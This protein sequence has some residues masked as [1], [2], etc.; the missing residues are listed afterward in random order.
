MKRKAV[1]GDGAANAAIRRVGPTKPRQ[2]RAP[3]R[4]I[5]SVA[6]LSL[7]ATGGLFGSTQPASAAN[8]PSYADVQAARVSEAAKQAEITVLNQILTTLQAQVQKTQ[9]VADKA[10]RDAQTAQT[11]FDDASHTA[12]RYAVVADAARQQST[13]SRNQAGEI[14]AQLAQSG[15][16]DLSA[17]I[18]FSGHEAD[19]LLSKLGLARMLKDQAAGVYQTATKEARSVTALTQQASVAKDALK[20]LADAARAA[21]QLAASEAQAAAAALADQQSHQIELNA[22]LAALTAATS[23]TEADYSAGVEAARVAAAAAAAAANQGVASVPTGE[24]TASGWT[25]PSAGHISSPYGYRIDPYNGVYALHEG[26]DLA[27]GC[28]SPIYAA[29]S[30]TVVLAG[31]YGGYGNYIRIQNSGDSSF[32]TAYGHIVN[33]GILVR[34]GD[35]VTVGQ[36]IARV[37]STGMSTGCH[38]HFEIHHDGATQDPVPFMRS[39]GVELAN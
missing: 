9:A 6:M 37:G 17:T 4:W 5:A 2:T 8:Y 21:L 7:L 28:N 3:R 18:F 26:T 33:G 16:D 31:P 35:T 20:G 11:H 32:E 23:V 27:P 10:G 14:A 13:A 22:E 25:R 38:L 24:I 36:N 29:H 12:A 34:V 15:G 1:V 30:G 39:Q 19:G